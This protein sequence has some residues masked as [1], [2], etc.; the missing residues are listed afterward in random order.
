MKISVIG[1]GNV[2]GMTAMRLIEESIAEVVLIDIAKGLAE[3]KALD[4]ED[5]L[6][7]NKCTRKIKGSQDIDEIKGSGITIITA[8]LA[9]RPG[10]S[11]EE[12][13]LKNASLLN[14][15]CEKIKIHCP[16]SIVIVVTNPV[17]IL[18]LLTLK[19]LNFSKHK[20]FGAGANLDSARFSNLI[21][22]EL[23]I[24]NAEIEATVIG[25]H[26][27]TMLALE[28]FTYIKGAPLSSLLDKQ[29]I[30]ELIQ[31]T[32]QRGARIVSLLG[33][34]SAY[35]APSA[36]ITNLTKSIVKDEKR[37]ICLSAYLEG[38][39][40]V[41]DLCIG[42]PCRIGS[43]GI[44]EIIEL[45]LNKEEKKAFQLSAESLKKQKQSL[46]GLL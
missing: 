14:S 45:D 16:D 3:A 2:G 39:Y 11:R 13:I 18:T 32:V 17:D 34:G 46:D 12:L 9:R 21:S 26:G 41:N 42:V 4:L 8:G 44:E 25:A 29:K 5:S 24:T 20:V 10:M 19:K 6:A 36:A 1:A 33:S 31:A 28:R 27:Q 35:F 22:H 15:I 37:N 30:K 38:E 43:Q 40:G 7:L 23:N